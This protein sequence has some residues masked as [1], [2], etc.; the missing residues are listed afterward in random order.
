MSYTAEELQTMREQGRSQS[1]FSRTDTMSEQELTEA[2]EADPTAA[3]CPT[4]EEWES[5]IIE[6]PIT[7]ELISLRL[8]ADVIAWFKSTEKDYQTIMN[9]VLRTYMK[10][11]KGNH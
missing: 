9:S 2:R 1:D 6:M 4:P 3:L 10:S 8:D 11:H 7:K 5:L